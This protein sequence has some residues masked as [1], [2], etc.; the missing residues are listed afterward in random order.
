MLVKNASPNF[1]LPVI[2]PLL[3]VVLLVGCV[4][5]AHDSLRARQVDDPSQMKVRSI[6]IQQAIADMIPDRY[7]HANDLAGPYDEDQKAS[8]LKCKPIL[9]SDYWNLEDEGEGVQYAGGF[10]VRLD[11]GA[12][13]EDI[14]DQ[15]Y[16]E[17]VDSPKIGIDRRSIPG[18]LTSD[19]ILYTTDGYQV[20][21]GY[22]LSKK[23][24][25]YLVD[26]YVWSPCF[27]LETMP[28]SRKI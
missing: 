26:V 28:P 17:I 12:P 21:V 15:V 16:T 11:E 19:T 7:T 3:A 24:G 14:V 23:G 22:F 18:S 2:A 1:L 10:A 5:S 25:Q 9:S 20:S 13:A 27:I 6:E 8:L 4:N